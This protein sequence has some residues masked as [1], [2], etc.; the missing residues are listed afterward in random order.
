MMRQERQSAI[1]LWDRLAATEISRSVVVPVRGGNGYLSASGPPQ[2][3]E[4]RIHPDKGVCAAGRDPVCA[5]SL[6]K[7]GLDRACSNC[8]G[9]DNKEFGMLTMIYAIDEHKAEMSC[10]KGVY[11]CQATRAILGDGISSGD[12]NFGK[13][14]SGDAPV[15]CPSKVPFFI[16]SNFTQDGPTEL[17]VRF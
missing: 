15:Y 4:R 14:F 13:D 1:G 6:V 16:H 7:H 17:C 5:N 11:S 10:E 3:V 2:E 12:R 9:V 8:P